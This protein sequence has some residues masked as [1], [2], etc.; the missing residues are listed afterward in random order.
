MLIERSLKSDMQVIETAKML[1]NEKQF[2]TILAR[3]KIT[4]DKNYNT[5][6]ALQTRAIPAKQ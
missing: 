1:K 6:T 5:A 2:N 4:N 3:D